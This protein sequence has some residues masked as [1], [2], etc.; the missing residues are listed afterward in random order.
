M[1]A[2]NFC[3]CLWLGLMSQACVCGSVWNLDLYL[4]TYVDD[5]KRIC[6]HNEDVCQF[7]PVYHESISYH[8]KY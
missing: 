7:N 2:L 6:T 4:T 1:F 3:L 5:E 8:R